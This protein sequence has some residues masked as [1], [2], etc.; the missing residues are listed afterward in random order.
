MLADRQEFNRKLLTDMFY[1]YLLPTGTCT[2]CKY[3]IVYICYLQ[4][5][6]FLQF[7]RSVFGYF[8]RRSYFTFLKLSFA[9]LVKLCR[10]YQQWVAGDQAAGYDNPDKEL[11]ICECS[12]FVFESSRV[13]EALPDDKLIYKTQVDKK[14]WAKP[15][16]Y[17]L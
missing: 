14:N 17:G 12:F 16:A 8:C 6:A 11:L 2:L 13:T 5:K 9:G 10:D 7:R 1:T 4:P 3:Q 15:E